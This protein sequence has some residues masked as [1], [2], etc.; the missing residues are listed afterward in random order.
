MS[1]SRVIA[2]AQALL[3]ALFAV[4]VLQGPSQGPRTVSGLRHVS[5]RQV[6]GATRRCPALVRSTR[7]MQVLF[8]HDQ[9]N[10]ELS[11]PSWLG[12]RQLTR[13]VSSS[14][15]ACSL[16]APVIAP[17]G[18][19]LTVAHAATTYSP[20]KAVRPVAWSVEMVDPPSL[21]PRTTAGE[22]SL[23]QRL[24]AADVLILGDHASTDDTTLEVSLIDRL[25][26]KARQQSRVLVVGVQ[27][28]P[29]TEQVQTALRDYLAS[30]DP[31]EARHFHFQRISSSFLSHSLTPSFT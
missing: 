24:A 26:G 28:L 29:Q 8:A 15:L 4:L 30:R 20:K 14:L 21:M 19:A 1:G 18:V 2:V 10:H 9:Q 31:S 23:L 25:L 22:D 16:V 3:L 6:D 27:A 12:S 17:P 5:T 11:V 13:L 7:S